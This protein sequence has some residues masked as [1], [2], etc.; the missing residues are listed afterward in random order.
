LG[1]DREAFEDGRSS[2]SKGDR[3]R[4]AGR[5]TF[6]RTRRAAVALTGLVTVAGLTGVAA[7]PGGAQ[8]PTEFGPGTGTAIAIAYK[9]NPVFGNLSFGI[10]AGESVAVHQNTGSNAQS[11]AVNLGVIGVTLAGEGCDGAA[12]TLPSES[13]PQPVIVG[14]DEPGAADGKTSTLGGAISMLAKANNN[15][16]SE[17]V[18]TVA[19]LGDPSVALIS[20]GRSQATSG[21]VSPGV[22][23]ARAVSEL[24]EVRLLNGAI[25]IKGMRWEAIQRTGAVTTNSGTFSLGSLTMGGQEVPLPS[26]G[27]D[28]LRLLQDVLGSVGLT[29]KAPATRVAE[30]IVF[31]DPLTIGI[32]PSTLRDGILG[33]LLSSLQPVREGLVTTLLQLGCHGALNLLG[34]NAATA[35]T[36]LDLALASVSGAGYLTLELGGVQATTSDITGF[37][38]L[39]VAPTLPDVSDLG[40]AIGD[41]PGAGGDLPDLDTGGSGTTGGD[42]ETAAEPISDTGDGDRGGVLLAIGAGGLLT[43]LATAEADRRKMRRAQREIL[44]ED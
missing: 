10:T 31:V 29:V 19:P 6:G 18:T 26:E 30:G 21:V 27:L 40:G 5:S 3:M 13:Q 23:E 12:P 44:L 32:V 42:T 28:Q 2:T 33:T 8:T 39:G 36:V 14:S 1:T 16:F 9:A 37:N 17:A 15:P 22:R 35:V 38:G 34:N 25:V 7:Q 41:L 20:G 11:K 43:L 4:V 24:G